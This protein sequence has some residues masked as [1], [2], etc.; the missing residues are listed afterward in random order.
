MTFTT[1]DLEAYFGR[2]RLSD[3]A[4]NYIRQASLGPSRDVGSSAFRAVISDYVSRKM[5]TSIA[6]ESRCGEL[7][8]A[9]HLDYDEDVTGFYDQPPQIDCIRTTH[10]GKR[11]MRVYYPD[12]VVF[13]EDQATVLEIKPPDE[14]EKLIARFPSDWVCENG[15]VHDLPAERAFAAYELSHRVISTAQ[16][17]R[18]RT[19]NLQ[20]L[21]Q[22]RYYDVAGDE[23]LQSR[24]EHELESEAVMRLS[25]LA[26][27]VGT[28]DYTPMLKLIAARTLHARLDETLL[29]DPESCWVSLSASVLTAYV[30][31]RAKPNPL[32]GAIS[33]ALDV[34]PPLK[35][36][37]RALEI[38][39]LLQSGASPR[40]KRRW[41][42]KVR[43]AEAKGL[44]AFSAVIP[45]NFRSGN[46][47]PKR[48]LIILAYAE[49]IIRDHWASSSRPHVASAFRLYKTAAK[50]WHPDA[51]RISR[52][53]FACLVDRLKQGLA[54]YRGGLRAANAAESPTDVEDRA[55]RATRPFELATCDHYLADIYCVMVRS[56]EVVYV[57]QPWITVLRDCATDVVLAVWLS[58]KRPSR[59]ACAMVL[60][61]CLRRHGRLP[62]AIVI[63]WGSE[64]RSVY[65]GA[66]LAHCGVTAT[67]RPK[68]HPRYGSEAERFFGQFKSLWLSLR[69]G[70]TTLHADARAVSSSH[71]ASAFA[72]IDLPS[73]HTELW[74]FCD[75]LAKYHP[76]ADGVSPA[77]LM[78]QGL[79]R[80][81]CSGK[82]HPYDS[83]F[84]IASAVD[85]ASISLDASRGL[86]V[87]DQHHW[88][89]SPALAQPHLY[90]SKIEVRTDPEDYT[91]VYARIGERW[92]TCLSSQHPVAAARDP[93][94]LLSA[95]ILALDG[96]AV[97]DLA[98]DDADHQLVLQVRQ[99]DMRVR[100]TQEGH[101][102]KKGSAPAVEETDPFD[103]ISDI[104]VEAPKLTAWGQK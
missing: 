19:A 56:G 79:T 94:A 11:V 25:D 58:F 51:Q 65:F 70:N 14:I 75:W 71:A 16:I 34:V 104:A 46:C 49:N 31:E 2:V 43:D 21:L 53:A 96:Q 37:E 101:S 12:F 89:W 88:Y 102:P 68:S 92:E 83:T 23:R 86:Q 45:T 95:S 29:S 15:Q 55:I 103:D 7:A 59:R 8:Y 36:A 93:M 40:S 57:Q 26:E 33:T 41:L 50:E 1:Q 69:P 54:Q 42:K 28:Q 47:L 98:R 81:P 91:R 3:R 77:T 73:L 6:T 84:V 80:F 99:A 100:D 10:K 5:G 82:P 60:R 39:D 76:K 67:Y 35:Q 62:E 85:E 38:L 17:S 24:I 61:S 97:R 30:L 66:L 87:G 32:K 63:D 18:I 48:P 9:I 74:Q 72:H 13:G 44:S 52:P 27:K 22:A 4:I 20:L 78:A 90:A 64:F